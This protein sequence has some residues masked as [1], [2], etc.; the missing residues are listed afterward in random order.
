MHRIDGAGKGPGDSWVKGTIATSDFMQDS[1]QEEIAN[2]I[3]STGASLVKVEND[4]LLIAIQAMIDAK[5]PQST[6]SIRAGVE[7]N[8]GAG[9]KTADSD[10][11]SNIGPR[12]IVVADQMD[13]LN[14]FTTGSAELGSI[15]MA[16]DDTGVGGTQAWIGSIVRF[17]P[18]S[19][20]TETRVIFQHHLGTGSPPDSH[21]LQ[22]DNN[23]VEVYSMLETGTVGGSGTWTRLEA[24][25]ILGSGNIQ[26]RVSCS[27]D[28]ASDTSQSQIGFTTINF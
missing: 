18:D 20:G 5:I 1:V 14:A 23:W 25:G 19:V 7:S 27:S 24:R 10:V 11:T 21:L 13:T 17:E 26:F 28:S 12:T 2:V 22:W 6:S 4:Q 9:I 16:A 15:Y 8:N 3:E